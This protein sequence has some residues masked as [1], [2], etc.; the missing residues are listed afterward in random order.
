MANSSKSVKFKIALKELVVEFEGDVQIAERLQGDITSAL[1]TLASAQQRALSPGRQ[2]PPN[3]AT[4]ELGTMP[5]RRRRRKRSGGQVDGIDPSIVDGEVEG[6]AEVSSG[7]GEP[8]RDASGVVSLLNV[9]KAEGYFAER[10][11]LGHIRGQMATKGHIYRPGDVS[12]LLVT[13]T[14]KGILRREKNS[15]NQWVYFA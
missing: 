6:G 5:T 3:T 10:R 12:P 11:T 4:T 9:L 1:S 8:R 13:A 15:A 14:R 2:Q 7:D